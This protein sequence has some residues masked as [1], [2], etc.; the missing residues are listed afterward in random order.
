M[1]VPHVNFSFAKWWQAVSS[2][3][4]IGAGIGLLLFT[5]LNSLLPGYSQS[6]IN[7]AKS[8]Q[9]FNQ[10][11]HDPVNA[12]YKLAVKGFTHFTGDT[13]ESTRL[14]AASFGAATI[15]LFYLGLRR[16]YN[17]RV[18]FLSSVLFGCSA[19]F[20]HIARHGTADVLLPFTI[21]LLAYC[22]YWIASEGRSKIS[23]LIA[24]IA[25][26]FCIFVPG[27]F[28]LLCLGLIIRRGKDFKNIGTRLSWPYQALL[29][30]IA[31]VIIATPIVIGVLKEPSITYAL[32]GL[33]DTLPSISTVISNVLSTPISIFAWSNGTPE[34]TLGHLPYVDIFTTGMFVLG[35]YYYFKYRSLDRSKLL[36]VFLLLATILAGLG[37]P[38]TDA[39]LLPAIYIIVAAG[40][41]LLLAQWTTVFPRNTLAQSAGILVITLAVI[42]S[43]WYNIRAYYIAWP[44]NFDTRAHYSH[45]KSNLIQ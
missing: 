39:I 44:L 29:V 42:V 22:G 8:S 2:M 36:A 1:N 18:A 34:L 33:P 7:S 15:I 45:T 10:I 40:I 6:E 30:L 35:A 19:W 11:V 32:L 24:V 28:W 23:Y 26:G 14:A 31:L 3:I 17:L 38:V 27:T 16:W 5:G 12:P 4:I 41:A 37:G 9:T 25:A 13:L 21:L 20:L 43:C